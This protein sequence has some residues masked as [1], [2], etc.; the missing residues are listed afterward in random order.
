MLKRFGRPRRCLNVSAQVQDIDIRPPCPASGQHHHAPRMGNH[1]RHP[2]KAQPVVDEKGVL[3]GLITLGRWLSANMDSLDLHA[4]SNARTP[5]RTWWRFSAAPC[6]PAMT[7]ATS[8][9]REV[10]IGTS[11]PDVWRTPWK[12]ATSC[13]WP[14]ATRLSCAPSRWVPP[15]WG[16]VVDPRGQ[17]HHRAGQ[18]ARLLLIGRPYDT[19]APFPAS[20]SRSVPVTAA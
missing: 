13:W 18:R 14:T 6:W 16:G 10:V 9:A 15:V 12:P 11:S 1:A 8:K 5:L 2:G 7:A 17:D 3:Q 20:S 4:L 19:Y